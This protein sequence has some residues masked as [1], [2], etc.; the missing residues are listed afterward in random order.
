MPSPTLMLV[1]DD[2]VQLCLLEMQ[3]QTM[4][5]TDV[6]TTHSGIEALAHFEHIGARITVIISDLTMPGMDG[7]VLMRH[8]ADR[9]FV[10]SFILLSGTSD[11]ILN[12]AAGLAQ[13]HHLDLLG[14]L[15]KPSPP[16]RLHALL[17]ARR[18][19]STPQNAT[20]DGAT[21]SLMHLAQALVKREFVPW[22]QPKVDVHTGKVVSVE[23]LARWP[24]ESG[25]MIGPGVFVPAI[26]AAGLADDLFFCIAKAVLADLIRWRNQGIR[27]KAAIN[28]SMDTA[29]NLD[30]PE[31][32]LA[33]VQ[34]AEVNPQDLIIEVTESK[35][36]IK[37]SVAMETLTRLSLMGFV[38]SIDDFG[39]GFSSLVQLVDLPFKELK[40]DGSFVQRA[41][42]ER[43]AA[44]IL[45]LSVMIGTTLNMSVV[46]EGVE[47][48]EQMK[49]LR[50]LGNTTVQGYHLA[51]P[52]PFEACTAWLQHNGA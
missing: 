33:L 37:R 12:S 38:L 20:P 35:L 42:A 14:V 24:V 50:E 1:D 49:F 48:A 25:G 17:G 8:L 18:M 6:I 46:A 13:A 21:L 36:M 40:I 16:E 23:A 7:L 10:G 45:R 2:D 28:M 9:G 27:V 29:L 41:L 39:T 31:Q 11:E 22:Y 32:L 43:K 4:G 5:Y 3:L 34:S 44:A 26:E 52:M 47:T 51:R 30:M 15:Q 19:R